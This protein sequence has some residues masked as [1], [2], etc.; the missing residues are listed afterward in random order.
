MQEPIT[1]YRI[2]F[3][4]S[5]VIDM[6]TDTMQKMDQNELTTPLAT[7]LPSAA[8]DA[9]VANLSREEVVKELEDLRGK[10]LVMEWDKTHRQLNPSKS[11]KLNIMSKRKQDLIDRLGE[12]QG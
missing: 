8:L 5:V 2:A 3:S 6:D 4:N 11:F 12:M 1:I 10:I 7:S 9:G